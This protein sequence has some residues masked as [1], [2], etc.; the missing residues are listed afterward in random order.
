MKAFMKAQFIFISYINHPRI[1][2]ESL[3]YLL[4]RNGIIWINNNNN[5][6]N[7]KILIIKILLK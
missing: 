7:N 4:F 5:N 6:N 1:T 3:S 2:V